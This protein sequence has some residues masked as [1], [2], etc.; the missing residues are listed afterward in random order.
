MAA[1]FPYFSVFLL[2]SGSQSHKYPHA[3]QTV[4]YIL[5][6][7][8]HSAQTLRPPPIL[9]IKSLFPP[10]HFPASLKV[11]AMPLLS[12]TF[13]NPYTAESILP[14]SL[15]TPVL[16]IFD[17]FLPVLSSILH[18]S[19]ECPSYPGHKGNSTAHTRQSPLPPAPLLSTHL[20]E[21]S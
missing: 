16:H 19:V 10:H 3:P 8:L 17:M 20:Q 7:L 14:E 15:L 4:S 6:S 21:T 9:L 2:P 11:P 12:D 5:K 13:L 1:K 18:H